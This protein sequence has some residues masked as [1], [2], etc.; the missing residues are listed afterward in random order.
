MYKTI[1]YEVKDHIATVTLNRPEFGNAFSAETYQEIIDAM[2]EISNDEDVKVAILTGKGKHFCTGGDVALFQ[3]MIDEN[4]PISEEDMIKTGEMVTSVKRN[5][6]PVIA[7]IN[8]AAAEAGLGLALACDFIVMGEASKLV[9][10]FI[11][12]AFPGDTA[13]VYNLQ[14]AIGTFRTTRRMMLSEPIDAKLATEYGIAFVVVPDEQLGDTALQLASYLA[15]GPTETFGQ[16]KALLAEMLYPGLEEVN[17]KEA[18]YMHIASKSEA[19]KAAVKAFT[20][21]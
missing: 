9:T 20:N 10:A 5:K 14:Q 17:K 6:K 8:G 18:E 4:Q 16:Q 11:G 15:N 2:N 19:H 1:L 3:K 13:L 12:M 7:A 21:K